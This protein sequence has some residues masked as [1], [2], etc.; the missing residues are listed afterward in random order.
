MIVFGYNAL[1]D[2]AMAAK[3]EKSGIEIEGL[4]AD[5]AAGIV[6]TEAPAQLRRYVIANPEAIGTTQTFEFLT[7]GRVDQYFK[8]RVSME[9]AARDASVSPE[10]LQLAESFREEGSLV[11]RFNWSFI[12][13]PDAS[14]QRPEAAGLG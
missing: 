3:L 8:G 12:T 7:N 1:I 11:S 4:A 9:S 6:S 5:D 10:Q 2:G 14:D 13:A